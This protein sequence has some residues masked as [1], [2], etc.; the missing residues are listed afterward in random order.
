[1]LFRQ[2]EECGAPFHGEHLA[3]HG[4]TLLD[5]SQLESGE[6]KK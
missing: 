6:E 4:E 1:M 2:N 5:G 3:L